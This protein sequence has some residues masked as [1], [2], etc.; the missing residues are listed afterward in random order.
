MYQ[1][2]KQDNRLEDELMKYIL[3]EPIENWSEDSK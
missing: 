1:L 2:R 3:K